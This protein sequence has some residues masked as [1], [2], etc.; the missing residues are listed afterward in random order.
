MFLGHSNTAFSMN[1]IISSAKPV[2]PS[3]QVRVHFLANGVFS[4]AVGGGN[5]YF[6][7]MTRAVLGAGYHV[8]Y[9]GGLALRKFLRSVALD[10]ELTQL[11]EKE[12]GL[13]AAT[14]FSQ[15]VRLFSDLAKRTIKCVRRL[16]EV[17]NRDL[18]FAISDYWFDTIPLMLCRARAK[19]LYLGMICPTLGQIVFRTRPDVTANRLSS[20]YY[21]AS[22]RFSL[23]CFRLCRNKIVTYGHPEMHDYLLGLGYQESELRFVSN[24]MDAELAI[25]TP[26]QTKVYDVVWTGRVHP[27]KGIDDLLNTLSYLAKRVADFQALIIGQAKAIL[28]PKIKELGLANRVT[29][30][31]VVSEEEKFRLTK[32][33]RVF[34]MP[35][36]YESWGIVIGEALACAVPVVAYDLGPYRPVFGDFVR[37]A[38]CFDGGEFARMVEEQVRAMRGGK[39]YLHDLDLPGLIQSLSWA[40]SR[41]QFQQ[42]LADADA[43]FQN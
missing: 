17:Q 19:I 32:A 28:E 42:V 34:V 12:V 25:R 36:R 7:Q 20:I 16:R 26:E 37:Y 30:S 15:Q 11:D 22:Q 3:S 2:S 14:S 29:F 43:K 33:S 4:D 40:Q 6:T 35:S 13:T 5:I 1:E 10:V 8:H 31:G 27:Q 21:W 24:G 9:F 41:K 23:Y 38:K 18:A 39:N